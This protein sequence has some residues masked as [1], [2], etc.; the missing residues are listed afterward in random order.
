M[1]EFKASLGYI[2]RLFQTNKNSRHMTQEDQ[3]FKA[4]L[5]YIVSSSTAWVMYKTVSKR[6][7]KR[8]GYRKETE[9]AK[10]LKGKAMLELRESALE[11]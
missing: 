8:S 6:Q 9:M 4:S 1:H 10:N 5:S 7:G 11:P 2:A 3:E